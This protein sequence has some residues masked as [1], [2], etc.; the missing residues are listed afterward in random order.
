VFYTCIHFTFYAVSQKPKIAF[1][2]SKMYK[3]KQSLAFFGNLYKSFLDV[4]RSSL[5]KNDGCFFLLVHSD[6][7]LDG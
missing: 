7:S 3:Q 2:K 5:E 4:S 1:E 6:T